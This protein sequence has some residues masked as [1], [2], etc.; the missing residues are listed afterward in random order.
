M[1]VIASVPEPIR[2]QLN[3]I[4]QN[5]NE[6]I[7]ID[8]NLYSG[9][10]KWTTKACLAIANNKKAKKIVFK[11]NITDPLNSTIGKALEKCMKNRES[12]IIYGS[13]LTFLEDSQWIGI[14]AKCN[15][16]VCFI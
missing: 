1:G 4:N 2:L 3:D 12:I 14:W 13:G 7:V 15:I 8:S 11:L 6:V 16:D 9:N 10:I 5:T